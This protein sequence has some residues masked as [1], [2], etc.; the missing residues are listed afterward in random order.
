MICWSNFHML[1]SLQ[2]LC[3]R[4]AK[5]DNLLWKL[6]SQTLTIRRVK[7]RH[8][9]QILRWVAHHHPHLGHRRSRGQQIPAS[10]GAATP[11]QRQRSWHCLLWRRREHII[12]ANPSVVDRR[13]GVILTEFRAA[14]GVHYCALAWGSISPGSVDCKISSNN[15]FSTAVDQGHCS[16]LHQRWMDADVLSTV[17]YL[18]WALPPSVS[19]RP[20]KQMGTGIHGREDWNIL[21]INTW[22]QTQGL[23]LQERG[24]QEYCRHGWN[25]AWNLLEIMRFRRVPSRQITSTETGTASTAI[26]FHYTLEPGVRDKVRLSDVHGRFRW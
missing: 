13:C 16:L 12:T 7:A 9:H 20:S 23:H 17:L 10:G 14:A 1:N 22:C 8:P 4:N 25:S 5:L 21:V 11:H 26:L 24:Q 6:R 18:D 19:D 2:I 3:F 15:W